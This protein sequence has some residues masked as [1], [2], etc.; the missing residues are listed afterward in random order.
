MKNRENIMH[1]FMKQTIDFYGD[2][3]T[4]NNIV[5]LNQDFFQKLEIFFWDE[6][7]EAYNQGYEDAENA[8]SLEDNFNLEYFIQTYGGNK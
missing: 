4:G 3:K 2:G 7:N 6:I 8:D 5:H 1:W